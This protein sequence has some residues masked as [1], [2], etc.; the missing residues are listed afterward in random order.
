MV[1]HAGQRAPRSGKWW[2]NGFEARNGAI[3]HG[4]ADRGRGVAREEYIFGAR[5]AALPH[6]A[7]CSPRRH[8][9][10]HRGAARRS[11][12]ACDRGRRAAALQPRRAGLRHRDRRHRLQ[13]GLRHAFDADHIAAIDNM[14]R[15]LME[16]GRRP[17]TVGFFFSLGHSTIVFVLGPAVRR[18][19]S[20]RSR[21]VSTTARAAQR[22]RRLIGTT[23]SGTFLLPHRG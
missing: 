2:K 16:E 20:G 19:A 18:R 22:H 6:A 4:G 17:L 7:R 3:P 13:L 8:G 21:A 5:A 12:G 11:A 9:S 14:T 1:A 15:K 10:G 23:V